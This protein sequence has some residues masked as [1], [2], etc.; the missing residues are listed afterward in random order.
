MEETKADVKVRGGAGDRDGDGDG[1]R[2]SG[3]AAD[4]KVGG[5]GT[6]YA[7]IWQRLSRMLEVAGDA[8]CG[9]FS[10]TGCWWVCEGT[11]QV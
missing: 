10:R 11:V 4:E 7:W 5:G 6:R 3:A 9:L 8:F 2:G 1:R